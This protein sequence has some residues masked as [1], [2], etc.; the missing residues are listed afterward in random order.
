MNILDAMG[1]TER[2][3]FVRLL[4]S[5][6]IVDY[7]LVYS[8]NPDKTVNVAH[9]KWPQREDGIPLP[10]TRTQNIE[11]LTFSGGG[12]SLGWDIRPGDQVLLLALK[13]YIPRCS[14][15]TVSSKQ[16][17][18]VHY[19]RANI[20]AFP[21]SVF[22]SLSDVNIS[23]EEGKLKVNTTADIELNGNTKE[24]VTWAELDSALQAVW[25]AVQGHTHPATQG[26]TSASVELQGVSLDISAA[27]TTT[28]KTGG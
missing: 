28:I 7:G 12:F 20:K 24:F 23:A 5:F 1:L 3:V 15:V 6:F 14:E 22:R 27:K 11:V 17:A 19:D 13:D 16:V 21:F 25:E 2:D 18:P 8:V 26:S 9:A 4:G 10:E